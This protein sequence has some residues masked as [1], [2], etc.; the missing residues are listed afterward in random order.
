MGWPQFLAWAAAQGFKH[1]KYLRQA[2]NYFVNKGKIP[3]KEVIL[4]TAKNFYDK[5]IAKVP[6][7]KIA[8]KIRKD[9]KKDKPKR[10]EW[11]PQENFDARLRA[12]VDKHKAKTNAQIKAEGLLKTLRSVKGGKEGITGVNKPGFNPFV[13]KG[14]KKADGGRIDKPLSGRSRDI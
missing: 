11:E 5:V 2:Y 10:F 9:I 6:T 3:G 8:D 13:I 7:K 14:G 1:T 12:I 4:K